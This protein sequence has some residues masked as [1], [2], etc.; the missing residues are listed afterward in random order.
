M[1][2]QSTQDFVLIAKCNNAPA[3]AGFLSTLS[4]KKDQVR[5]FMKNL[6]HSYHYSLIEMHKK[7]LKFWRPN[8]YFSCPFL[9]SNLHHSCL[10]DGILIAS[11]CRSASQLHQADSGG[12]KGDTWRFD[13]ER[14]SF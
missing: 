5:I 2:D 13:F 11:D 1:A 12:I 4:M 3:M 6:E 8:F 10:A 14:E 7:P 9:C